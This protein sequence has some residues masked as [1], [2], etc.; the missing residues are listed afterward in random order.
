M[1]TEFVNRAPSLAVALLI[2][3]AIAS[4]TACSQEPSD[5]AEASYTPVET[6]RR[7]PPAR[8]VP[9]SQ[10][11][12]VSQKIGDAEILLT[13]G[14][15]VARGRVVFGGV[16]KYDR[17]WSPGAN[18][19]TRV[20]TSRDLRINGGPL[21]PGAYSLW[22][23]PRSEQPWTIIFSAAAEVFHQPYPGEGKDALRVSATPAQGFHMETLAFY[24]PVVEARDAQLRLHW[25][26]LIVSLQ[27]HVPN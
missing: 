22:M 7:A 1:R 10:E 25:G 24:F 26:D 15:P 6:T 2:L 18:Q 11:G 8:S 27:I 14:R 13:Y 9:L 23:I 5:T 3:G 17:A 20:Y 12:T 16:V 19:A 4:A 21:P